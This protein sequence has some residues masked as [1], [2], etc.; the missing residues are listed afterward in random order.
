MKKLKTFLLFFIFIFNF[1]HISNSQS[2]P[3]S[4]ADLAEKLNTNINERN[5]A[6][7]FIILIF[8]VINNYKS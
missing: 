8:C 6:F 1:P 5:I 7:N 3:S 4:F 2:I